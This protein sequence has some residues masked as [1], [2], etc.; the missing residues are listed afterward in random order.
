MALAPSASLLV[1]AVEI[2]QRS[3]DAALLEGVDAGD[4][5][6][7]RAVHVGDGPRDPLAPVPSGIAV[8]QLHAPRAPR[9]T[10]RSARRPGR[11]RRRRA[12]RRP[13]PWGCLANPRSRARGRARC[14]TCGV[15]LGGRCRR[16]LHPLVPGEPSCVNCQ[17]PPEPAQTRAARSRC[18]GQSSASA[19]SQTRS[20]P[21]R[22]RFRG[23]RASTRPRDRGHGCG[24]LEGVHI[25]DLRTCP[26]AGT[27]RNTDGEDPVELARRRPGCRRAPRRWDRK[28]AQQL[29]IGRCHAVD[30]RR[31]VGQM[32][33]RAK[34]LRS[35]PLPTRAARAHP[36]SRPQHHRSPAARP[37]SPARGT[38]RR[39]ATAR[40]D[41]LDDHLAVRSG[42]PAAGPPRRRAARGAPLPTGCST[43]RK[44]LS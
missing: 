27:A 2:E 7:D 40:I 39:A 41:V 43:R 35:A 34:D 31:M 44:L 16:A 26:R 36:G 28:S 12:P 1:G 30:R 24:T 14:R 37:H 20:A 38:R 8:A 32:Q 5:R 3:V 18:R 17:A 29:G 22:A 23:S 10:R 25:L 42:A 6:R 21:A 9:W 33:G 13:P 11:R 15:I 19:S 4:R